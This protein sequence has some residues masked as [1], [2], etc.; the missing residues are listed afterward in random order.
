MRIDPVSLKLFLAVA[1]LGTIAAAAERE[2]IAASAVS[3]RIRDL[4]DILSTQLLARSNKGI[5]P[6]AAGVALQNLSRGIVNDLENI[7]TYMRDYSSG[8]RGLVRIFANVSTIAEFLP[9]DLQTFV[10]KY[11]LVQLQLE[12]QISTS[13]LRGVAQNAADIGFY[14]DLGGHPDGVVTLP[15]R[16]DEL[17]VVVP[18]GHAF[19]KRKSLTINE[20]LESHL[21]GLETGSFINLQLI[22]ASGELGVPVKFRMQV[23][24]YDAVCLMVE[25]KMGLGILPK[26]LAL[27][28]AKV[29]G[30]KL[31]ALK[32]P[33]AKRKLNICIRSYESLPVAARL[34]VDHLQQITMPPAA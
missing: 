14:A 5:E 16:E 11:P 3:K 33:W 20:L 18:N 1:E 24:S 31:V 19:S 28:Y 2:H 30:I 26:K 29:L 12:E 8:T 25:A 23:N 4:E 34:L 7:Y 6:T 17:V 27:R 13:I 32:E 21:I 10:E 15:Y 9:H 22:K